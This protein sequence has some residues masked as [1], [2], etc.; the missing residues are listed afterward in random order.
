MPKWN[1][2]NNGKYLVCQHCTEKGVQSWLWASKVEQEPSCRKCKTPWETVVRKETNNAVAD[3]VDSDVGDTG[4][5][6][7]VDDPRISTLFSAG[8]TMEETFNKVKAQLELQKAREQEK[9][10][11]EAKQSR[12]PKHT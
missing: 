8:D 3:Y 12:Q 5:D 6:A 10:A 11:E 4:G 7:N 2:Q 1:Q 9:Q